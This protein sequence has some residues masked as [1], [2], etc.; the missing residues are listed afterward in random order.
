M[1][2][3]LVRN[4]ELVVILNPE[5]TEDE[6]AEAIQGVD[7]MI[8]ENG[9]ALTEHENWGLKRLAFPVQK[10]TEGNYV[11]TRFSMEPEAVA[12]LNRN[13]KASENVLKVPRDE[14][15]AP[16]DRSQEVPYRMTMNKMI[17]I[18][19]VGSDPEMR[20]TPNGNAVTNF[21]VAANR[22]YN[23][24]EGEQRE[25]TEWFRVAA[26]NRLAETCNQYVTKG[27]KVYVEGRLSSRPYITQD[28]QPRSGN[29]IS[30]VEVKFLTGP[31]PPPAPM[32]EAPRPDLP[33]KREP[34]TPPTRWTTCPGSGRVVTG[35]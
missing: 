8:E 4:Y 31:A 25:E 27:M 6:I 12:E 17:V 20:Y 33:E 7:G 5:T 32:P 26:W 14:D 2:A 16:L 28:G 1:V 13:L 3:Q 24:A 29:E 35:R 30:A 19:N 10:F 34:P 21:S 11:L 18:G 9:G 23:T 15:V 22:R